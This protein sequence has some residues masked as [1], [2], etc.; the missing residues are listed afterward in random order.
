MQAKVTAAPVIYIVSICMQMDFLTCPTVSYHQSPELAEV[1]NIH[2]LKTVCSAEK[3]KLLEDVL[4]MGFSLN[5]S[6]LSQF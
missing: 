2:S 4:M 1:S 6:M 5:F 3:I